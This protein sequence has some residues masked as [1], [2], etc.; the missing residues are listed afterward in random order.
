M[1]TPVRGTWVGV[2][3]GPFRRKREAQEAWHRLTY[4]GE[5][6]RPYQGEYYIVRSKARIQRGGLVMINRREA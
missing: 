1:R 2:E 5:Y 6:N 3:A 4:R